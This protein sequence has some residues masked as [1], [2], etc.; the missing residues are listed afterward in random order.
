MRPRDNRGRVDRLS[1]GSGDH[2][3]KENKQEV[4]QLKA[5]LSANAVTDERGTA[6]LHHVLELDARCRLLARVCDRIRARERERGIRIV[7]RGASSGR[8]GVRR[9]P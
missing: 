1:A 5:G 7:R 6:L 3:D 8:T 2:I 9:L 4:T